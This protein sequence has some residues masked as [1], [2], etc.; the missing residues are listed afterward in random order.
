MN[1]IDPRHYILPKSDLFAEEYFPCTVV[2]SLI[3][4]LPTDDKI[5]TD[6]RITTNDIG[7]DNK[8]TTNIIARE[9]MS[10]SCRHCRH[11]VHEGRRGG[12]CEQLNVPVQGSWNGCV[13]SQAVFLKDTIPSTL[14]MTNALDHGGT[15]LNGCGTGSCE[16]DSC[17]TD[18][19]NT[20]SC[21]TDSCNTRVAVLTH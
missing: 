7:T 5:T 4:L 2:L 1:N 15:E 9:I 6:D 18:S 17:E 20:D 10:S 11:Y 3:D 13:L 14:A 16:A 12:Q 19:C 8:I 21:N